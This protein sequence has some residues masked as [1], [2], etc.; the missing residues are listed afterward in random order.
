MLSLTVF[1]SGK[2]ESSFQFDMQLDSDALEHHDDTERGQPRLS[3]A[4]VSGQ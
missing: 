1:T 3:F 4:E 2:C